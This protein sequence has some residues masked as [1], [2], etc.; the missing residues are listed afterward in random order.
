MQVA[1]L[2]RHLI[3]VDRMWDVSGCI[4]EPFNGT[5]IARS[6]NRNAATNASRCSSLL[7]FPPYT[8]V[9]RHAVRAS[10]CRAYI[11]PSHVRDIEIDGFPY[12]RRQHNYW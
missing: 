5:V 12:R 10:V 9:F 8:Q 7:S 1:S 2:V 11:P 3:L 6:G 4:F